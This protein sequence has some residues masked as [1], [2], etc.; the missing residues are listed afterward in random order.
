MRK[1][2][3]LHNRDD[4]AITLPRQSRFAMS[5]GLLTCLC[6]HLLLIV[7]VSRNIFTATHL[8]REQN[9][10]MDIMLI[11][12]PTIAAKPPVQDSPAASPTHLEKATQL[13]SQQNPHVSPRQITRAAPTKQS[14]D[15]T[16]SPEKHLNIQAIYDNIGKIVAEVDRENDDTPV[17]QLR[18]KPLYQNDDDNR[19]AKA[20]RNTAR[21][22]CRDSI[23]NTG[24]LAPLVILSMALD[25]KDSG[26]KW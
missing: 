15:H 26:C 25:K 18:K 23:A 9:R 20:I 6:L 3:A 19:I 7:I 17:G 10:R 21:P 5:A 24:L 14:A 2:V 4:A 11:P 1:N 8:T 12:A 16:A 13:Q 22:D